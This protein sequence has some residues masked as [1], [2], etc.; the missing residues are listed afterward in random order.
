MRQS[1]ESRAASRTGDSLIHQDF[2][3]CIGQRKW[4]PVRLRVPQTDCQTPSRVPRR[5][6]S[7]SFPAYAG[8]IPKSAQM[9]VLPTPPFRFAMAMI[10]MFITS[11]H[12]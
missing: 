2:A 7:T 10:V 11:P 5:S 1:R 4:Q 12:F 9:V 3:H 8:P 6:S